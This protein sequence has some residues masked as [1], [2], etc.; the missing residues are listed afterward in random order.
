MY[1][2]QIFPQF[3]LVKILVSKSDINQRVEKQL[4]LNKNVP[5]KDPLAKMI[6]Y[7]LIQ[8]QAKLLTQHLL[9]FF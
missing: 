5:L 7:N 2:R 1:I 3:S 6:S 9:S 4:F 8:R